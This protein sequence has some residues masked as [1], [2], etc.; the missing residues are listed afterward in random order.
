MWYADG[1][2]IDRKRSCAHD[3]SSSHLFHVLSISAGLPFEVMPVMSSSLLVYLQILDSSTNGG[4][5]SIIEKNFD[6]QNF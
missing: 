2:V 4:A 1:K 3:L 6:I 5:A